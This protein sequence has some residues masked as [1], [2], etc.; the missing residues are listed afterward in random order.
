[1]KHRRFYILVA[2]ITALCAVLLMRQSGE[3]S[4]DADRAGT[5]P[6][7]PVRYRHIERQ[8]P[9]MHIHVITV[10]L[11]DPRVRVRVCPGGADPDGDGP[12]QTTLRSVRENAEANNLSCAVNGNFFGCKEAKQFAGRTI[13]YFNGNWSRVTGW[14]MSDGKLWGT[15][16]G[17]RCSLMI[18]RAG[19]ATIDRLP[20]RLP[21][22]AREIVTGIELIVT[23]GKVTA[24]GKDRAPRT[25]VGID[26]R[27]RTLFFVVVDGRNAEYSIGMTAAELANELIAL[28]CHRAVLLDGGGS[29][30]MVMRDPIE[31]IVRV[32]N[33]PS[34]GHDLPISMSLERPVANV[35][36]VEMLEEVGR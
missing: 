4:G 10:D 25:S 32:L 29:S 20:E 31:K 21:A 9:P 11:T 6:A 19:R 24:T 35:V 3:A 7:A 17:S 26:S 22:D 14:A 34:D 36:G 23:D 27:G 2:A 28:G 15:E 1:M 12:W 8:P 5:R 16:S 30:T 13:P 18:D 33:R